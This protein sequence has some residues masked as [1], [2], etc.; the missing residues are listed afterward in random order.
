MSHLLI[1]D[2]SLSRASKEHVYFVINK[3]MILGITNDYRY[4]EV[5]LEHTGA[6]NGPL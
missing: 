1:L 3:V 5:K 4:I 2:L 6:C